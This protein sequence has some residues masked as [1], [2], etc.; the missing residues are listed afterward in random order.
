M[1]KRSLVD[2]SKI[3]IGKSIR[4]EGLPALLAGVALLVV[5]GGS[6]RIIERVLVARSSRPAGEWWQLRASERPE[7]P[8]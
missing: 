5:A 7:L 2:R 3:R 1:R 4:L 6:V 8:R